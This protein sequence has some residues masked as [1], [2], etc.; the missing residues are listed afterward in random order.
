MVYNPNPSRVQ[1]SQSC[2]VSTTKLAGRKLSEL[3]LRI[4]LIQ[5]LIQ[6][7]ILLISSER[8][9]VSL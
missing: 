1:S 5:H 6:H 8:R 2:D 3:F 4:Y 9:N 7:L